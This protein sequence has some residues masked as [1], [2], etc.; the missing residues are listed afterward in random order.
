MFD[1]TVQSEIVEFESAFGGEKRV[2]GAH[3]GVSE[4]RGNVEDF[5]QDG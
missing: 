1:V 5:L 3:E 2:D 4:A